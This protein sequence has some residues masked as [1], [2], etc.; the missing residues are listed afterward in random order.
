M[1]FKQDSNNTTEIKRGYA[2]VAG[3]ASLVTVAVLIGIK[4]FAYFQSDSVSILG[5]LVDSLMDAGV[6]LIN[7]MAIRYSLKPADHEHRYGHGKI[8]GLAAMFQAAFIAGAGVFLVFESLR[9]FTKPEV[10]ESSLLVI[11]IMV[12]SVVLSL[13][14]ILVQRFSLRYAPSLAVEAEHAHYSGD[15]L[16]NGGVIVVLLA[17]QYGAP[18]WLDPAFAVLIACYLGYTAKIIAEKGVNMLLD[19]ELPDDLRAQIEDIIL[20]HPEAKGVHDLRT[21]KSGMDIYIAFDLEI[22]PDKSLRSAHAIALKVERKILK[23]FPNAEIMIHT[24]P[25]GVPHIDSRN[26]K[27]ESRDEEI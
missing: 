18:S 3:V 25:A 24:D 14:L 10:T 5:S 19:R 21:R 22:D 13:I 2:L 15:I 17:L 8:E 12:V 11:G 7:F 4:G 23:A 26:H 16:M 1:I 6:S 9:R 20:Q 27:I